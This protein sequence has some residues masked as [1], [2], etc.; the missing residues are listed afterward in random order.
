MLCFKN[1]DKSA[2]IFHRQVTAWVPD[3][4]CYFYL[5]K[6]AIIANNSTNP[7]VTEKNRADLKFKFLIK[8]FPKFKSNQILKNK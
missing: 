3:V 2:V 4:F 5:V 8:V 6:N 7:D 1:W